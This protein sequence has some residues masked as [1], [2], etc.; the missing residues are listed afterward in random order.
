LRGESNGA[1]DVRVNTKFVTVTTTPLTNASNCGP[2]EFSKH[3]GTSMGL[4]SHI[5]ELSDRHYKLEQKIRDEQHRPH[6]DDIVLA[7]LKK[8]KLRLKEEI[9]KLKLEIQ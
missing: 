4:E 2:V 8:K 6:P 7:E 3:G 5:Q 1:S 9:E